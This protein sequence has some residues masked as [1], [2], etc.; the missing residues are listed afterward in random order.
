MVP[1]PGIRAVCRVLALARELALAGGGI[2]LSEQPVV[3]PALTRRVGA[4]ERSERA[5]AS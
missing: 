4:N 5:R 1:S 2:V 3:R